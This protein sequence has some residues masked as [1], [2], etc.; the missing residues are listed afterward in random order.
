MITN[1]LIQKSTRL[2]IAVVGDYIRDR[3]VT[4]EVTRV[5]PEAPVP[6][7]LKDSAR[8][9][10]GGAGNVW[11]NLL[12]LGVNADLY[13]NGDPEEWKDDV[14][15]FVNP[16]VYST[17]TR[18]MS[19][20]HHL[21]RVDE[22][23]NPQ[24]MPYEVFFNMA[25]ARELE[26]KILERHY[27]VVVIA[28]YHKGVVSKSVAEY[29]VALCLDTNTTCIV[30]A[31]RDF[32]R[33]AGASIV[34]CNQKEA[35]AIE[36]LWS[37][38]HEHK[39]KHFI[40]TNGENGIDTYTNGNNSLHRTRGIPMSIVDT[41]GAGD[42]VTAVLALCAGIENTDLRIGDI[43]KAVDLAN[44]LAAESCRHAGVYCVTPEDIERY[45]K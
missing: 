9:S 36:D 6:L 39:F 4:G 41:C 18:F 35:N 34:K 38:I 21:L 42:I 10:P 28:D 19:G 23:P 30:D 7:M 31:K 11:A 25:W 37:I 26:S 22:E 5:S 12:G 20:T 24:D 45:G 44:F 33:F 15:V 3:Y 17:K 27:D 13:C 14:R 1:E 32:G 40:V 43:H 16:Q 29:I 2:K 8:V